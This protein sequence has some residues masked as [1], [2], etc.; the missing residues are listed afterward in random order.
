VVV[1][2]GVLGVCSIRN[3]GKQWAISIMYHY[4]GT[5]Y[6]YRGTMYHY[7]GKK[8]QYYIITYLALKCSATI[9]LY[10]SD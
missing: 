10:R 5:M 8:V 1:A 7:H 9:L 3:S 6:H 4:R 2:T